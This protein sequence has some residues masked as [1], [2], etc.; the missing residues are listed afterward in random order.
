MCYAVVCIC[1]LVAAL[2]VITMQ[3]QHNIEHVNSPVSLNTGLETSDEKEEEEVS[4]SVC[5]GMHLYS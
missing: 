1:M 3:Q 4:I 5:T 2:M